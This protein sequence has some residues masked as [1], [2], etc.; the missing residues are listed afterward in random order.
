MSG[1]GIEL[2]GK[3]SDGK[4][5][6]ARVT[7]N[8]WLSLDG[9]PELIIWEGSYNKEKNTAKRGEFTDSAAPPA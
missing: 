3:I 6:A 7:V 8:D 5:A 9:H 2:L 4:L 1:G